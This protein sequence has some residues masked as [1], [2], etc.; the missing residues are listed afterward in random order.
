MIRAAVL[1]GAGYVGR[2]LVRLLHA[3][4]LVDLACVTSRSHANQP[5]YAAHPAFRGV[6][7]GRFV[8][9]LTDLDVDVVFIAAGHGRGAAAVAKLLDQGYDGSIIDMSADFRLSSKEVY[10]AVY[11]VEHPLPD[12]IP[13]FVYG[14]P[15]ISGAYPD[16]TKYIANPG[17]FA[18]AIA[19]AL[20]PLVDAVPSI[21]ASVT[22]MTGA[23][24]SGAL[25]SATTH[26]PDRNGNVR[27]YRVLSHRHTPEVE[28]T[29]G[30]QGAVHITPVSGPWTHGIW[31]TASVQ[32]PE[33]LDVGALFESTFGASPI[34]R[35]TDDGLP[36]LAPVVQS[37][38]CDLGWIKQG[39][40]LVIGFAL[41]NLLKGAASQAIQNMN[42][43]FDLDE[44]LGLIPS[45]HIHPRYA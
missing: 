40:E 44:T 22:A 6:V 21:R 9:D 1:H 45:P 5:L 10:E 35:I 11:A 16:A 33:D 25:A 15:E 36:E 32:V 20:H 38:F 3:H 43:I 29:L 42:L 4:P 28:Q 2:E 13:S 34:I 19:L 30:L 26:F 14:L 27:A 31:G 37:P 7:P 23:S 39:G 41:D 17:C 18:T 12:L 24:G 8:E